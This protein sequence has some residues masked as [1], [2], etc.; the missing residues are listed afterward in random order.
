MG[1]AEHWGWYP[2]SAQDMLAVIAA[3][4]WTSRLAS[5]PL[6]CRVSPSPPPPTT[7][8]GSQPGGH[9]LYILELSFQVL[10]MSLG[11]TCSLRKGRHL[12]IQLQ[13]VG[14]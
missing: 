10:S 11:E 8:T 6:P 12:A 13:D 7:R 4:G 9:V 1:S 5:T 3:G 2:A 14:P